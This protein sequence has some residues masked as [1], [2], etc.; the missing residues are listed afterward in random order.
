MVYIARFIQ[1]GLRKISGAAFE[2][3]HKIDLNFHKGSSKNTVFAINRA[4]RSI[5]AALRFGVGFAAPVALEFTLLCAMLQ[6][7][8]GP[9][10]LANM[11][12]TLG[13]YVAYT[14]NASIK[15]RSEIRDRK[16]AE[17]R[18]EFTQNESIINYETVK[19]FGGEKLESQRYQQILDELRTCANIV[20]KSLSKLN[21]GQ[22][23]IFSTGLTVNLIMAAY[24][25][26]TGIL[27]PGDFVMI[28]ALFL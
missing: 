15:R 7:Y 14:R 25:V 16:D 1:E 9:I 13:F 10:Y 27:T 12:G 8:C 26:S 5:E 22:S 28:Q 24:Q 18:Q 2:H 20:Q 17:K 21:T 23:I 19:A 11:V 3:L 4:I 6:I